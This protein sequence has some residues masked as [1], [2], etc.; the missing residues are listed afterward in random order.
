MSTGICL[1][2]AGFPVFDLILLGIGPDGHVASLFPNRTQTAAREGWV[3]PVPDSPKPPPERIT[4]T[5]PAIN[6]CAPPLSRHAP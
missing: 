2:C 6:S 1:L 3:L 4:L 5:L